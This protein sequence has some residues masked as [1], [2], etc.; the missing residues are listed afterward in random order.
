MA[1]FKP[2][3]DTMCNILYPGKGGEEQTENYK[4][5]GFHSYFDVYP[6]V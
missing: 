4:L 3:Y 1:S 5:G 6:L 2:F